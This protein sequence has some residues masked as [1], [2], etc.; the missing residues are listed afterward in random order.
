MIGL[1]IVT[2]VLLVVSFIA[3][4]EKTVR[5][6]KIGIKKFRTILPN[7][8]KL[9]ILIAIVLFFAEG[10]IVRYLGQENALIGL[11]AALV[12]GSV[13]I[14]PGFIAYPLAGVLVNRGVLYMV[15][16]GFVITLQMVGVL[17]Y[18]VEKEYLGVKATVIRNGM[19]FVIAAII[20]LAIGLIFGEVVL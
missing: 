1:Y 13:T 7:Y 16:A 6:V 11:L 9:L 5:G 20:S 2:G 12:L 19:S 18:P 14:M 10:L 17:T 15:V 4:R 3:D 8:L